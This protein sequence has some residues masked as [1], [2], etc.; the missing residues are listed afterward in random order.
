[1]LSKKRVNNR[2]TRL[3]L[4]RKGSH[5]LGSIANPKVPVGTSS[6]RHYDNCTVFH[7][8]ETTGRTGLVQVVRTDRDRAYCHIVAC[9]TDRASHKPL[10]N[11]GGQST[12]VFTVVE[13]RVHKLTKGWRT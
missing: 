11:K 1:M 12:T 8:H 4:L 10:Q 13:D 5:V 7:T 6:C 9:V 3:N 2:I